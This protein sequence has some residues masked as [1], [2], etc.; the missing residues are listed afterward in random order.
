MEREFPMQPIEASQF[1]NLFEVQLHLYD[2]DQEMLVQERKEQEEIAERVE[3]SNEAFNRARRGDQSSKAREKA[4]QELEN[5]YLK[6][7]ELISNVEVGRKFYNDLAK[8][9]SRF[10]DDCKSFVH[11]RRLEASQLEKYVVLL[12]HCLQNFLFQLCLS[13]FRLLLTDILQ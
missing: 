6:Y 5:G 13:S 11:Q 9:V 4:L 2:S 3:E 7:K 1:E 10:R 12:T 8:I